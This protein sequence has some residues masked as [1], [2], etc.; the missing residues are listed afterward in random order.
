[1]LS[2]RTPDVECAFVV[3]F[4][5]IKGNVVEFVYPD[6]KRSLVEEGGIDFRAMPSGLHTV[7]EDFVYFRSGS[8][9]TVFGVAAFSSLR[10]GEEKRG[11]RQRSVGFL[12]KEEAWLRPFLPRLSYEARH[13]NEHPRDYAGIVDA[14]ETVQNERQ[15]GE[16]KGEDAAA[17][18]LSVS[19]DEKVVKS[20]RHTQILSSF[21]DVTR[22]YGPAISLLRKAVLLGLRI[23][24]YSPP[25][26]GPA[27]E[28]AL[29]L[30]KT[31]TTSHIDDSMRVPVLYS[32]SIHDI[33]HLSSLSSFIAVTTDKIFLEKP[34][35]F[36]MSVDRQYVQLSDRFISRM[37]TPAQRPTVRCLRF[38]PD[39]AS[40]YR[41]FV[42]IVNENSQ[43]GLNKA[44]P[45]SELDGRLEDEWKDK[46]E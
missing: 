34:D 38:S 30:S 7:E 46:N 16:R 26:I 40:E 2:L 28:R 20:G 29:W 37:T 10:T 4:D 14:F 11:A 42:K 6:N 13:L 18:A 44:G 35:L 1:L 41:H 22:F 3:N 33:D 36:D 32:V 12:L 45:F 5:E 9:R 8:D 39:D 21:A 24:I 43:L 19:A 15:D 17:S 27:C 23:L 25:P 31:A